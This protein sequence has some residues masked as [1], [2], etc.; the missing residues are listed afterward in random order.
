M[1]QN[2]VDKK[3]TAMEQTDKQI[4]KL[5]VNSINDKKK[6][7][8]NFKDMEILSPFDI[9]QSN[10]PMNNPFVSTTTIVEL[11]NRIDY[12]YEQFD[13]IYLEES[14]I[15]KLL[16]AQEEYSANQTILAIIY[17]KSDKIVLIDI[18]NIDWEAVYNNQHPYI[19]HGKQIA[20]H[21]TTKDRNAKITKDVIYFPL[22]K[23]PSNNITYIYT[24]QHLDKIYKTLYNQNYQKL[25]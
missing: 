23:Q 11:K 10:T 17:P 8:I 7:Q 24:L 12:S 13:T 6:R 15:K 9:L 20:A 18:S 3:I 2:E 5:F 21:N 16:Q 25:N 14:K 1:T 22:K 4:Y 19:T